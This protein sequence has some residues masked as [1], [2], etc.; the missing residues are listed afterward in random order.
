M[1]K[2]LEWYEKA[3]NQGFQLSLITLGG[4]YMNGEGGVPKNSAK[5]FSLFTKLAEVDA[6]CAYFL[7]SMYE[8]GC[9]CVQNLEKA[10]ECFR[11]AVAAGNNAPL[12]TDHLRELEE[13]LGEG[14]NESLSWIILLN[15]V[16]L[17]SSINEALKD[18]FPLYPKI[19]NPLNTLEAIRE[20][21]KSR[22]NNTNLTIDEQMAIY[23]HT[24]KHRELAKAV[25]DKNAIKP[26]LKYIKLLL[27]ALYKLP[28]YKLPD[29]HV[30]ALKEPFDDAEEL[31]EA[32]EF[33][34]FGKKNK[35]ALCFGPF[36][37]FR[38]F[39]IDKVKTFVNDSDDPVILHKIE[40]NKNGKDISPYSALS[41]NGEV[42]H[43]FFLPST[44][45]YITYISQSLPRGGVLVKLEE[46]ECHED[47]NGLF[48]SD[49]GNRNQG[50]GKK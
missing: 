8:N 10:L 14:E 42:A 40:S 26:Y 37:S 2:A 45:F 29:D 50:R 6:K 21:I 9:G 46:G 39:P 32:V 19:S 18:I 17:V 36:P 47:I 31:K 20:I 3:A 4:I 33:F 7:G 16:P 12:V 15:D 49:R 35:K 27:H 44:K 28:P 1:A 30:L 34:Q 11:K 48:R 43:L 22:D 13:M 24:L 25:E 5:A 41:E 38:V 23:L